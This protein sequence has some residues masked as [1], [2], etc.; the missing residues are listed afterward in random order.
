M[1]NVFN[2]NTLVLHPLTTGIA[3]NFDPA[4]S[5]DGTQIAFSSTRIGSRHIYT[6]SVGCPEAQSGCPPAT[7]LTSAPSNDTKPAWSPDGSSIAFVSNR[8][9][10]DQIYLIDPSTQ[11]SASNPATL[12]SDGTANYEEPTWGL[13]CGRPTALPPASSTRADAGWGLTY[14]VTP[15]H[16]LEV[17]DVSL[18]TRYMAASMNLPYFYLETSK[19]PL[20]RCVLTADGSAQSGCPASSRLVDFQTSQLGANPLEIKATYEVDNTSSN[21]NACV[22]VTQDYQF[23]LPVYPPAGP[24]CEPSNTL[25][26]ARFAPMVSYQFISDDPTETLTNI[27]TAQRFQ[28][29]VDAPN[30]LFAKSYAAAT[31]LIHDC[32][33]SEFPLIGSCGMTEALPGYLLFDPSNTLFNDPLLVEVGINA[34]NGGPTMS[35]SAVGTADN[36]HQTNNASVVEP[37]AQIPYSVVPFLPIDPFLAF[38]YMSPGC[39]ECVHIH[40]RWSTIFSFFSSFFGGNTWGN[41]L[42]LVPSGPNQS[43]QSVNLGI[44]RYNPGEEDPDTYA[45]L[46]NG[47][48]LIGRPTVFWYSATGYHP[49]DTFFFHGGFFSP[50]GFSSTP[51]TLVSSPAGLLVSVDGGA[52]QAAPFTV[53]LPAGVHTITVAA[54]QAGSSG[55]QFVFTGWS[56]AGAASHSITVGSSPITYTATFKTQYQLTTA[57]SP[58]AGGTLTPPNGTFYDAGSLVGVQAAGNAGYLFANFSGALTGSGNPQNVSMS[59]PTNVVANFTPLTPNL[60]ASV[61]ARTV[62][63]I[64]VLVNLTLTNTGPGVATNATITSITAVTDVAGSGAVTEISG[65]PTDLGTIDP[66]SSALATVTFNWPSTATRV[67]FTVNFTADGSYSSSTTITTLR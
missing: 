48:S 59:G 66:G 18:G 22:L 54:I 5:P 44:I 45:S 52:A 60:A 15:L 61:G 17:D 63:G 53:T 3:T 67:R 50:I 30:P 55:T 14:Q 28:F 43:N 33:L 47:E 27:N 6:M 2:L 38:N 58:A 51:I 16:G 64:T 34:I 57:A 11:E 10:Q 41:G 4:W 26:C 56:D 42:P 65:A 35:A 21:P 19:F 24:G 36:F 32:D 13:Q 1:I 20:T 39:P 9:G 31:T 8:I 12:L 29:A 25:A 7:Q 23:S 37:G 46:I 40:W 49:K 62:A